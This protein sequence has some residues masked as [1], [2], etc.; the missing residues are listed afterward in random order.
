MVDTWYLSS[1]EDLLDST[2]SPFN[3]LNFDIHKPFHPEIVAEYKAYLESLAPNVKSGN[4]MELMEQIF[5]NCK[6]RFEGS[7][8]ISIYR[9]AGEI[10]ANTITDHSLDIVY[11]DANHS[12]ES[13]LRDLR[14]YAPKVK[15]DGYLVGNDYTFS[16][17]KWHQHYGVTEAVMQFIAESDFRLLAISHGDYADFILARESN[18]EGFNNLAKYFAKIGCVALPNEL[19]KSY[20][21]NYIDDQNSN[22]YIPSFGEESQTSFLSKFIKKIKD[23]KR[24]AD[25]F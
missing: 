22:F 12:Y 14:V 15:S 19:A 16:R 10:H 17:M 2:K 18:L 11:V 20:F 1:F 5:L 24:F 23:L 13:C 9:N 6:K 4:A 21:V 7:E 25:Q 3:N 8:K